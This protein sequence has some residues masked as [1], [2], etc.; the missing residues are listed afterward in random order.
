MRTA[1]LVAEFNPF[2]NGHKYI[3]KEIKKD[4]DA[5][6]VIMS[7]SFVQRGDVAITDKHSRA[8]AALKH[9]ADLVIELPVI[10]ALNTAQKFA[11]GAIETLN[12]TGV[13]D[14]LVFGSE[15][16][17]A[18]ELIKAAMLLENESAETSE[19]I[20][21]LNSCG[22]SYP[23]AR[24]EA[25]NGLIHED[26][27]SKPNNILAVEYIRALIY[28]GSSIRP[29]TIKRTNDF[30]SIS[31]ESNIIS[32]T[33][34]R[35]LIAEGKNT[36]AFLPENDFEVYSLDALDTAITYYLRTVTPEY[37]SEINDINEGLENRIISSAKKNYGF[38][39]ICAAVKS[40]RYTMSRIRRTVLSSFLGLT[41]ELCGS[42]PSY[43]RVLG[44]NEKGK[45]VLKEMK[46]KSMLPIIVKTADFKPD[47]IFKAEVRASEA[48]A[49]CRKKGALMAGSEY[50]V[51]PVIIKN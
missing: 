14:A 11:Y 27:L 7:G 44:M 2:H 50:T 45:A 21:K 33:A 51:S 3:L 22:I 18:D 16:G 38:K 6:I 15:S 17:N 20:R 26:I 9:G 37:L 49:L 39:A 47:E 34:A 30:H 13:T 4:F 46:K 5:V 35:Q 41:K 10:Y 42:T 12:K 32:A 29:Y 43:I 36:D 1:G 31:S 48:A 24:A 28:T 8:A 25:Y 23:A 40:K 19:R